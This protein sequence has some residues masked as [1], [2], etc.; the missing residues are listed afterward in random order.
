MTVEELDKWFKEL[1]KVVNEFEILPENIYNMDETGFNI[2]DFEARNVIVD[3]N[4]QSRYQ[5]QPDRQE[6]VSAIECICVDGTAIPPLLIFCG[7]SFINQWLP[8]NFDAQ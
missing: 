6:W 4:I 3:S 7:E 1:E 8:F 5:V 2:G